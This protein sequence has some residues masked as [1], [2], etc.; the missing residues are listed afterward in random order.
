M[1]GRPRV[2]SHVLGFFL[3]GIALSAYLVPL[4]LRRKKFSPLRVAGVLYWFS[5]A[6]F[7][8][9]LFLSAYYFRHGHNQFGHIFYM[10]CVTFIGFLSGSVFPLLPEYFVKEKQAPEKITSWLYAANIFGSMLGPLVTGFILF[11]VLTIQSNIFLFGLLGMV[12]GTCLITVDSINKREQIVVSGA[13]LVFCVQLAYYFPQ[14]SDRFVERMNTAVP[15]KKFVLTKQTRGGIIAVQHASGGDILIGG[16]VYDGRFNTDPSIDSNWIRRTYAIAALHPYPNDVLEIGLGSGSWTRALLYLDAVKKLTAVEI[17]PGYLDVIKNYPEEESIF[18]DPRFELHIDDGRR[19]LRNNPDRRF[20]FILINATYHWRSN[21][22]NLMSDEFLKLIKRH[23]NEGGVYYCNTTD[24]EDLVYTVARNFK[25]VRKV[26]N[27]VAGSDSPFSM[28]DQDRRN[29]LQHFRRSNGP[30]FDQHNKHG[31]NIIDQTLGLI[32]PEIGDITRA[33]NDLQ[34]ITDD[35][36]LVE[37]KR[38]KKR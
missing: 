2:F 36:M 16:G 27:I 33:R 11:D 29:A 25:Y 7:T 3:L 1:G 10:T 14:F 17:N 6:A 12:L 35:N 15:T 26:M 34:L 8:T 9:L 32:G 20:D 22:T 38:P 13:T 23:L 18:T 21:S 24:S 31:K 30:I 5:G 28:S 19:W 4:I 37:Y